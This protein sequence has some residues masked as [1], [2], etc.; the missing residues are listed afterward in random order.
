[1]TAATLAAAPPEIQKQML[2]ERLY[3][4]M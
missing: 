2:G 3:P 4:L 1:L